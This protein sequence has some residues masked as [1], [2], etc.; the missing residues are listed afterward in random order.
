[1]PRNSLTV[2]C[3]ISII[4]CQGVGTIVSS[5]RLNNVTTKQAPMM[6]NKNK[7]LL[8]IVNPGTS[9]K[10]VVILNTSNGEKATNVT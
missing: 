7:Q 8:A 5:E 1:M 9:Q 4:V 3:N 6:A 2:A 10:Y